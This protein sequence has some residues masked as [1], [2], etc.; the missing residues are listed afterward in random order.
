MSANDLNYLFHRQQVEHSRAK[1]ARTDEAR[2]VHAKL[3]KKYEEEIE[4][5]TGEEFTFPSDA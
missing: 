1:A 5:L 2:E 4:K 3:A